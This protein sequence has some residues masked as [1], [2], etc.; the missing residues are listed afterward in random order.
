MISFSPLSTASVS[1]TVIPDLTIPNRN[2]AVVWSDET[3]KGTVGSTGTKWGGDEPLDVGSVL[4]GS[5]DHPT[6]PTGD[7]DPPPQ[8]SSSLG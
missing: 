3:R 7:H 6:G 4:K 2:Y 1:M 8:G 5:M